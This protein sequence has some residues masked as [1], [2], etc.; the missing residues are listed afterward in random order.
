MWYSG[1]YISNVF[2]AQDQETYISCIY[3]QVADFK[4][5]ETLETKIGLERGAKRQST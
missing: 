5:P 2:T 1:M 4:R 3:F